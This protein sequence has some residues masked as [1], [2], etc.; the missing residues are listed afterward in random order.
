V[1]DRK[2]FGMA[3]QLFH[4]EQLGSEWRLDRAWARTRLSG[5]PVLKAQWQSLHVVFASSRDSCNLPAGGNSS[6]LASAA[7][8]G[9]HGADYTMI[10]PRAIAARDQPN[11]AAGSAM[12]LLP[13]LYP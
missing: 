5:H 1:T 10:S 4:T 12:I 8:T 13:Q 2:G 7:S 3:R 6:S 11:N 9:G